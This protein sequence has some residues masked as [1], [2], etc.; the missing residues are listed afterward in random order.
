MIN[1]TINND[2]TMPG[3]EGALHGRGG[4]VR[5]DLDAK[6][7]NDA[8]TMVP[9]GGLSLGR[10]DQYELVRELGG[11]GFGS[12]Y[13]AKDTVAGI[14]VAVKGLPP[15]IKNNAEELERIRENFALVSRLHHPYIA[16]ALVLHPAKEVSYSSEDVRQK[17]RVVPGDTLM[18][19]EYAPGVTLSKWRRQ[20]PN[21]KVPLE[22]AI[23]I[24]WQVAQALDYAHE[25]HIIHRDI[26]PANIMVETQPD[27]EAVARL[28]DFGLAA[29]VRSSMGRVSREIHDT[30]G[31]RPYMAPEQW[32][33]RKQGPATDQYALAVLLYEM[34]TG[35]VPFASVFDTGDPMV[36]MNAVCNQEVEFPEDCPRKAALRRALAKDP[37]QRFASCVDFLEAAAE[38][39]PMPAP[40]TDSKSKVKNGLGRK[41]AILGAAGICIVFAIIGGVVWRN[42]KTDVRRHAHARIVA[43][44][45]AA[46]ERQ[47]RE[48]AEK[49]LDDERRR[50]ADALA[51]QKKETAEHSSNEASIAIARLKAETAHEGTQRGRL[52]TKE[53]D[54]GRGKV[55]LW[56]G[57]P[58]WAE[59]N[60]GAEK[61]WEYGLYF[62]WGDIVGYRC[63]N[64]VWMANDGSS[65]NFSFDENIIPT[66]NKPCSSLKSEGWIM[67]DNTLVTEHDAAHIQWGGSW[68]MPTV[69]ELDSLLKKC[70]LIWTTTNGVRGYIVCGKGDY[71]SSRIFLP[72]AGFAD[73]TSLVYASW[74]GYYWS[75]SPYPIDTCSWG[76]FFQPM[77]KRNSSRRI[78]NFPR[79]R[80]LPIRPVQGCF[81]GDNLSASLPPKKDVEAAAKAERERLVGQEV[82]NARAESERRAAE[83]SAHKL[84]EEEIENAR[85]KALAVFDRLTPNVKWPLVIAE[86][87]KIESSCRASNDVIRLY[88]TQANYMRNA[89]EYILNNSKGA[90]FPVLNN[91]IVQD[92]DSK[93]G[94]LNVSTKMGAATV[95]RGYGSGE[96]LDNM[97]VFDSL[98]ATAM[99]KE[100]TSK[101]LNPKKHAKLMIGAALLVKYFPCGTSSREA[102]FKSILDSAIKRCPECKSDVDFLFAEYLT[103]LKYKY[104]YTIDK[105]GYVH[106]WGK[107]E[108]E[109][110]I[111][112][113]PEGVFTLPTVIDGHKVVQLGWH[114]FAGCDKMTTFIFPK[115]LVQGFWIDPYIFRNCPKLRRVVFLGDAPGL[116]VPPTTAS[117]G[118]NIFSFSEPDIAVEVK[119]G[120]KGWKSKDSTELPPRWPTSGYDSRPIRH[121]QRP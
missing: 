22:P 44:R 46:L 40:A 47:K 82:E 33:G 110:C 43:E 57:G 109:P 65:S 11:G 73:K 72:S 37:S 2:M 74:D 77:R 103:S 120:S 101:R 97:A 70:E 51:K 42:H 38:S 104:N 14:E 99:Q 63:V 19:M 7:M 36:M 18:V 80:G 13:L 119:K 91:G 88:I 85:I 39:E 26:K 121:M 79:N 50:E 111:S 29:E 86:L 84:A 54:D 56:E 107:S 61:P 94:V 5:N 90:R 75:S 112:P 81:S 27:G 68:R 67:D 6:S 102:R 114:A 83:E 117:K 20:F 8:V 24:A 98:Y 53:G 17:L 105:N 58:Y 78:T 108:N 87:Y 10:I 59:M 41:L 64:G 1:N 116:H 118:R 66:Y 35:E 69:Q 115:N 34:L 48:D 62:W 31:T 93:Q 95:V 106:L 3:G 60:I 16:A 32:T 55:Q 89:H 28:L 4:V 25:H 100:D 113:K 45:E 21:G 49:R 96:V 92:Y 12:V 71:A 52:G 15:I 30:S 76:L 23:Q 9:G